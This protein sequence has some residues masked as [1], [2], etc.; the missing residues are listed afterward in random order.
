MH[1]EEAFVLM[2]I[3]FILQGTQMILTTG[4]GRG[5]NMF[6]SGQ[7]PTQPVE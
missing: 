4:F 7:F 6:P 3:Q 5:T 1:D 2:N